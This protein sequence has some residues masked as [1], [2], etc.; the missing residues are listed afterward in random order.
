MDYSM[1]FQHKR[2]VFIFLLNL[3]V[4][5]TNNAYKGRNWFLSVCGDK[6]VAMIAEY[7]AKAKDVNPS[8]K[9]D[10]VNRMR[11]SE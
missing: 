8:K 7:L 1:F 4:N 11:G 5:N 9:R 6:P 10:L 2:Y 3:V